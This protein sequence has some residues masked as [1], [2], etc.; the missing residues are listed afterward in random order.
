MERLDLLQ[1]RVAVLGNHYQKYLRIIELH[2]NLLI[3]SL[4][5]SGK[6]MQVH[7]WQSSP[8]PLQEMKIV[9]GLSQ[10]IKTRVQLISCYYVLQYL[11]MH[12][13]NLDVLGLNLASNESQS[14]AYHNFMMRI[15]SDFRLLTKAY[16]ENLLDIYLSKKNRPE[17]CICSVGTRADQDDIDIGIFTEEIPD[18]TEFTR[19]IRNINQNMLVFATPLHFYLSEHV[20]KEPYSSTIQE[21]DELL[22]KKIQDVVIIS[23]L[24][25]ARLITGS[26]KFFSKF[27]KRILSRYYYHPNENNLYHEG[28]LR[29]ILG[30]LRAMLLNQP[31]TD[32]VAPKY[33]SIRIL[34]SFLYAKKAILNIKEVNAWEILD[35][36]KHKEPNLKADYDLLNK[37]ISFLEL[38]KF[39]LQLFVIQEER[40]RIDELNKSQL[41]AIARRMGYKPIGMVSE[42]DQV[43]IDYYRY[44]REVRRICSVHLDNIAKHM[45]D[46]SIFRQLKIQEKK[47][48]NIHFRLIHRAKFFEGAKFWED[49]I[50]ILEEDEELI[51]IF[52]KDF[53]K[54]SS[55]GQKIVIGSYI[56]WAQYSIITLTRFITIFGRYQESVLGYTFFF[57]LNQAYLI[58][59]EKM[60]KTIEWLCLIFSHYPNFIHQYFQILPIS[61]FTIINRILDKPVIVDHLKEKHIHL[62]ELAYLHQRSSRYFHRF[63]Y[64]IIFNHPEYL[65]ALTDPSETYKV[66][67]GL[68]AMVDM[69]NEPRRRKEII[70]NYYDF[71]FLR[72]GIG[73]LKGVDL[74]TT[75]MQFTEFCDKYLSKLFD[76]CS[77]EI[78]AEH[79]A[80]MPNTDTIAILAAGG[81]AR[82]QAYEDDYDLIALADTE[83][84]EVIKYATRIISRMNR[85]ILERGLLPHYRMGEVLN[86]FVNSIAKVVE[87]LDSEDDNTFIDLSQLLGARMIIG[88]DKMKDVINKKILK[89]LIYHKKEFYIKRMVQE[90]QDRHKNDDGC[91]DRCNIKEA[92]GGI[93]D[94]E[95][96]ALMIKVY[97]GSHRSID[98]RFFK[99]NIK[100][101][102]NLKN[103]LLTLHDTAY[104]L[105]AVRNFYRITEAAEDDIQ[106]DQLSNISELV[107]KNSI[108]RKLSKNLF[109]DINSSLQS[110]ASAIDKIIRYLEKQVD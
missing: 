9:A 60:P 70:G 17:F 104:F 106:R 23:E 100:K 59:I 80:Q 85:N 103:E 98:Q 75:N 74:F 97:N 34:K 69:T 19:A 89:P 37:A 4:E 108:K 39:M 31:Q 81:H 91:G 83:N 109:K 71:E 13:R 7:L 90:V 77:D 62:R 18:L 68:L 56:N 96:V 33:D 15:G 110:S 36:L 27:K 67:S 25:N 65:Q 46:I 52:L 72:I 8:S 42:W 11:H 61:H 51:E 95:A 12:F 102:P 87:Y 82:G 79:T 35:R 26:A 10:D 49:L 57:K 40:F 45:T 5:S 22:S 1:R 3:E 93:R 30:E 6:L 14:Q 88:S 38:F 48:D 101:F 2:K 107:Y 16:I 50:Q 28:Y 44:V 54:L 21:Y 84:E 105:R 55:H 43:L 47:A 99:H 41:T 73:T 94:I 76:I 66:S 32:S 29:G 92:K 20:G 78:A 24:L 53:E 63:F 64:R 58:Y 86:G